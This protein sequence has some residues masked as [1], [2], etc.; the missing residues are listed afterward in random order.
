ME[1]DSVLM[2]H[3]KSVPPWTCQV[4][5]SLSAFPWGVTGDYHTVLPSKAQDVPLFPV[6][7]QLVLVPECLCAPS[8][9]RAVPAAPSAQ[10]PGE[11]LVLAWVMHSPA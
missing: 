8:T 6:K 4:L 2:T 5:A 9:R 3:H 10:A 11:P 7:I 1:A